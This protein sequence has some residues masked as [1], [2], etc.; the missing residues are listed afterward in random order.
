MLR[1]QTGRSAF[2]PVRHDMRFQQLSF[3]LVISVAVASGCTGEVPEQI[4]TVFP[5]ATRATVSPSGA[6]PVTRGQK[7]VFTVTP[8]TDEHLLTAVGGDCPAG[9]WSGNQYTTGV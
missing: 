9:T 7:Q 6:V 3:A 5:V 2:E 4:R 8:N 1:T